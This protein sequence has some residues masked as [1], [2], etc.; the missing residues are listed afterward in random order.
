[1][2]GVNNYLKN[3]TKSI[4]Y[5]ASDIAKQDLMSE[6]M[7]F[8]ESNKEFIAATYAALKNP[9]I[10]IKKSINAIQ[11]SK[12]YQALDYGARNVVEDL[13]TGNF[14]NKERIERDSG[15]LSGMDASDYNDLSEFG[16]D[17]DWEDI[18]NDD[19]DSGDSK[20]SKVTKEITSGDIEI[21][22]AIEGTSAAST[23][24]TVNA[25][26]QTSDMQMKNARINT[27][28]LYMQNERLFGGLHKDISV[29]G[30][31]VDNIQK[32][33]SASLQNIDKNLSDFFT[34]ESK[35]SAER[36]AILK[37]MVEMQ[38]NQYKSVLDKEKE[39]A[40]KNNKKKT[41]WSDIN[42][43]GMPVFDDYIEN[44]KNNISKEMG[45]I[46]PS[47]GDGEDTNMFAVFATSPISAILSP[48]I[49]GLIPATFKLASQELDKSLSSV[50]GQFMG[51][52]A[53]RRDSG[54]IW[55]YVSKFLGVNTGV[56]R[57]IATDRYEKGPI[58]FDGITRK[59]ITD[60]IPTYL[61]RI[62]AF[63]TRE[64]EQTFDY[65][66]GRWITMNE[67]KKKHENI[68]KNAVRTSTREI[69]DAM[70]PALD[71]MKPSNKVDIESFEKAVEEFQ[72]FL[73]DH[74][75]IFNPNASRERN[76]I[77]YAR[78]PNLYK[79]YREITLAYNNFDKTI[80]HTG[81]GVKT[82]NTNYSARLGISKNV[83]DAKDSEE[84]AY[85][86]LES[87][88]GPMQQYFAAMN[89]DRHGKWDKETGKFDS[90]NILLESKDK[91]GN[92]IFSYL[93]NINAELKWQRSSGF[94]DVLSE[95]MNINNT[96]NIPT[97]PEETIQNEDANNN[98]SVNGNDSSIQYDINFR[99][100]TRQN[101]IASYN[102][103]F[104]DLD[105]N[106]DTQ[107]AAEARAERL[108][109]K[110]DKALEDIRTGKA[111]DI[112]LLS[113][114]DEEDLTSEEKDRVKEIENAIIGLTA[115]A[116]SKKY[117]EAIDALN[118]P[119][120]ASFLEENFF[121]SKIRSIEDVR[122]EVE[123]AEKESEKDKPENETE[124]KEKSIFSGIINKIKE[125]GSF[126]GGIAGASAEVFTNLMYTADRA[127]YEMMYKTELK[128]DE[129]AKEYNGF[130]DLISGK[131]NKTFDKVVKDIK[132]SVIE[133]FKKRLGI[134]DDWTDQFKKSLGDIGSSIWKNFI[135]AN[136]DVY[137]PVWGM[138]KT[139]IGVK[140][141]ETIAQ[142]QRRA[143]RQEA[144][145]DLD[146]AD[147]IKSISDLRYVNMLSA[148]GLNAMDY[149]TD[150][151]S[152]MADLRKAIQQRILKNSDALF[153]LSKD[154][155]DDEER[156]RILAFATSAQLLEI[157][158]EHGIKEEEIAQFKDDLGNWDDEGLRNYIESHIFKKMNQNA[159]RRALNTINIEDEN[160]KKRYTNQEIEDIVANNIPTDINWRQETRDLIAR[161]A[162]GK[163]R[164]QS[165]ESVLANILNRRENREKFSIAKSR[166]FG[167]GITDENEA[168]AYLS[169]IGEDTNEAI[170]K[171][172]D[173]NGLLSV[174]KV[175]ERA[176]ADIKESEYTLI[177]R[178]EGFRYNAEDVESNISQIVEAAKNYNANVLQGKTNEE[179]SKILADN[180][181]LYN[182]NRYNSARVSAL[183]FTGSIDEKRAKLKELTGR[184]DEVLNRLTTDEQLD[185]EY[186]DYIDANNLNDSQLAK[187]LGFESGKDKQIE[188]IGKLAHDKGRDDLITGDHLKTLN[189]QELINTFL[190]L[191]EA[192]LGNEITKALIGENT[193]IDAVVNQIGENIASSLHNNKNLTSEDAWSAE[194]FRFTNRGM[195]TNYKYADLM[196]QDS[197]K[198]GILR[199]IGEEANNQVSKQIDLSQSDNPI[200]TFNK[201][202]NL[203]QDGSKIEEARLSGL[204]GTIKEKRK[205]TIEKIKADAER[206]KKNVKGNQEK[207]D[208]INAE[209]DADI[210]KIES[211]SEYD[212]AEYFVRH[213]FKNNAL[214]TIDGKPFMGDTMLS[215][216]ELLFNSKGVSRVNKTD[217][218]TLKEPT[219]ILNSEDSYDLLSGL[220]V[221]KS[222]LGEK[223]TIEQDLINEN[224][225]KEK[226]IRDLPN[227]AEGSSTL[228]ITN[229]NLNGDKILAEAKSKLPEM[230]AGGLVGGVLS[231]VFDL[232]GGPLVGAAVGAGANLIKNSDTLK[233]ALFGKKIGENGERDDS[234]FISKTIVDNVR[235][236]APDM[237]K[238]GLAGIIPGLIT[239]I[240]PIGGLLA[241][242]AIGIIKNNE[243]FTNKYFGENGKLSIKSKDKEIIE[244]LIPGA[245]KG[246]GAGAIAGL[247]FGGPFGLLGNAA[248]GSVVGMMGATSEFKE[249]MLGTD[250]NG[251]REGGLMGILKEAFDPLID[252]FD[253]VKSKLIGAIDE[254]IVNPLERFISPAIHALPK[255]LSFIP[256]LVV[257][258]IDKRTENIRRDLAGKIKD[259]I[260]P[261]TEFVAKML[262]PITNLVTAPLKIPGKIV[263]GVG[264]RLR[265]FDIKHG[266]TVNMS[267]SEAVEWMDEHNWGRDV[268]PLMR[269][270]ADVKDKNDATRTASLLTAMNSTEESAKRNFNDKNHNLNRVLETYKTSD[271]RRLSKE[272]INYVLAHAKDGDYNKIASVLTDQS[273]N[274]TNHAMSQ[275][276]FE[277]LMNNKGLKSALGD[278]AEA[279]KRKEIIRT[280]SDTEIADEVTLKLKELGINPSDFDITNKKDRNKLAKYLNEQAMHLEA[281]PEEAKIEQDNHDNLSSIN[282]TLSDLYS[283]LIDRL[284]GVDKS[285]EEYRKEVDASIKSGEDKA[286]S[287]YARAFKHIQAP[288]KRAGVNTD[289]LNDKA[290]DLLTKNYTSII[291]D[292][293]NG[294]LAFTKSMS[295][296]FINMA[297]DSGISELS[298]ISFLDP[299][300][301]A[302]V[303]EDGMQAMADTSINTTQI[304]NIKKWLGSKSEIR[305]AIIKGQYPINAETVA[306]LANELVSNA[307]GLEEKCRLIN[308]AKAWDQFKSLKEINDLSLNDLHVIRT[309][310]NVNYG[311][312]SGANA[313][314][315]IHRGVSGVRNAIFHPFKTI[316]RGVTAISDAYELTAARARVATNKNQKAPE[317]VQQ[318]EVPQEQSMPI[319]RPIPSH[320][321]GTFLLSG[322][323]GIAKSILGLFKKDKS[324][325]KE[326][327]KSGIMSKVL[328]ALSFNNEKS[329]EN[330][331]PP[332]YGSGQFDETDDP[333]DGKD[334]VQIGADF[335][336]VKR[337]SDGSVEL[338]TGDSNT[339]QI[340]NKLSLKEKIAE[341]VQNAQ[342]KATEI[343]KNAF[344]TS[345]TSEGKSGKLKWW[346]I[347][348]TGAYLWKSGVLGKLYNGIVKP[349]WDNTLK[350]WIVEKALPWIK[351][352]FIPGIGQFFVNL[353][354]A[355]K[356]IAVNLYTD[357][358]KPAWTEH[359]R[360]WLV[361]D[362]GPWILDTALPKLGELIGNG[363]K[364]LVEALPTILK[365]GVSLAGGIVDAFTGNKYN[366]GDSTTINPG[367]LTEDGN[368]TNEK[369]EALTKEDVQNGNYEKI[370]NS[371]GAEGV[372]GKDGKITFKDQSMR[373]ASYLSTTANAAWHSFINPNVGLKSAEWLIKGG[374]LIDKAVGGHGIVGMA[375]GK[376]A[377]LTGNA[378][379]QPMKA[380][381][382]AGEKAGTSGATKRVISRLFKKG[383][384]EAA[385]QTVK[386]SAKE[387]AEETVENAAKSAVKEA[388]ETTAKKSNLI[389]RL[390][391]KVSSIV[392]KL[393]SNTKVGKYLAKAAEEFGESSVGQFTKKIKESIM[394][395]IEET[396]EKAAKKIGLE[397]AKELLDT[398]LV[399]LKWVTIIADFTWGFDRAESILGVTECTIG[400][401]FICGVVNVLINLVPFLSIIVS[402][403]LI[404][405]T[406]FKLLGGKD[407]EERQKEADAEYEK[408]KKENGSTKTKEEYLASKYSVTGKVGDWV[409]D[410]ASKAWNWTKDNAGNVVK[411]TAKFGAKMV[412]NPIWA[413]TDATKKAMGFLSDNK[414]GIKDAANKFATI[415]N[416]FKTFT[417]K[418]DIDS[419]LKFKYK[420]ND[421]DEKSESPLK[422]IINAMLSGYTTICKISFFPVVAISKGIHLIID[423]FKKVFDDIKNTVSKI[424]EKIKEGFEWIQNTF[425]GISDWFNN[426][427]NTDDN[428]SSNN[429]SNST[430]GAWN[431]IKFGA[432]N[433]W[434]AV[435]SGVSNAWKWITGGGT[436]KEKPKSKF[437]RGYSKQIDPAI[438]N[439]RYNDSNDTQYQT[440]G[441]SGCGPAA[442][443]NAIKAIH[444]KGNSDVVNAAT[445]ALKNGYKEKDGGTMPGFFNDY[446]N[447]NG[448]DSQT[449]TNKTEIINNINSGIPTVLMGT[450]PNGVSSSTP[451]GSNPHYVTATG[452]DDKGRVIIQ[453]PES[454]YDDQLYSPDELMDKTQFGI[455]AFGRSKFGKGTEESIWYYL[456]NTLKMTDAGAAGLMGNLYAESSLKPNNLEG[457][458]EKKYGMT[459]KSYTEAVDKGTYSKDRF[460]NDS[461]GYGLAQWTYKTRKKKLYEYIKGKGLSIASIEG[462]L[463]YL[464][465]ELSEGYKN[466]LN[467]LKKTNSLREAS[468]AVM[469]KFERPKD[470]SEKKRQQ[471]A[472]YGTKYYNKFSGKTINASDLVLSDTSSNTTTSSNTSIESTNNIWKLG[473]LLSNFLT[474]LTSDGSSSDYSSYSL[475]SNDSS[476]NITTSDQAKALVQV[477]QSQVGTKESGTNKIKYVDWITGKSGTSL[478]W[479]A[480]FVAWCANQANIPTSIIPKSS[481]C[482]SMF[483]YI[484]SHGGKTISINDAQPGDLMFVVGGTGYKHVGIVESNNGGGKV[485]TIEGNYSDKV[486]R[487]NRPTKNNDKLVFIRPAYAKA[488]STPNAVSSGTGSF[489]KYKLNDAQIK[490]VANII[491]HEQPDM[492][493]YL[494]EA[495]LMANLTDIKGDKNATPENLVKKAT[496]GWF[497]NGSSRFKNPG[498]P[499][500]SAI[501]AAKTVLVE[502][503]RTLPRYIDEHD[504]FSDI[505][506]ATNNGKAINKK[507]RSSYKQHTTKIKNKYGSNWTFY[508]FPSSG[509]DPFGYTSSANKTKWGDFHYDANTLTSGYGTNSGEKPLAKYGRFKKSIT[510]GK[511]STTGFKPI[512][513]DDEI[514][515]VNQ[516][517]ANEAGKG[518]TVV[519]AASANNNISIINL[520]NTVIKV[521]YEIADN[522][523]KLNTII[524]ILN[525][526]F[527]VNITPQ[528]VSDN[529]GKYETLKSKLQKSLSNTVMPS[530]SSNDYANTV[531]NTSMSA[532][533]EIMN[534][535][536]S[537]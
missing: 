148:Y 88:I 510:S 157:A 358:L 520:I 71:A 367:E 264:D 260:L 204:T 397:S 90:N 426:I 383:T 464:N 178:N 244:K 139:E 66:T 188:Q 411:E 220:G 415:T 74:N 110:L 102:S 373:G 222:I 68:H 11:Q 396:A 445:Y 64:P 8:A 509:S 225:I 161:N 331:T 326:S 414:D 460:V 137:G 386:T 50:F 442:A 174:S 359:L 16:I 154:H 430:G 334:I 289:D 270:A 407:F 254:N 526:N 374:N 23:N 337:G 372:V 354:G 245:L 3:V 123:K 223:S 152:A 451:Y 108:Q 217:A 341:K 94:E 463:G 344:D 301:Q 18:L 226:I 128:D 409:K 89:V 406:I 61:R 440:I 312:R 31:T 282:D 461:A 246:A 305:L 401:K 370:Y 527:N 499:K 95:L 315:D 435:K 298:R 114:E 77:D 35:L 19:F 449:I 209:R 418:G 360:P 181:Q 349:L 173:E 175:I 12:I 203:L 343:L 73:Y 267:L 138:I 417:L 517:Q 322:I 142:K 124:E 79:H 482:S 262:S 388:A 514:K 134:D 455:S 76:D 43:G 22:D 136:K 528:D 56:N 500:A 2:K 237:F 104:A 133:P 176:L 503:K 21:V 462:Q 259:F 7:D 41:R 398:A 297:A 476:I 192:D 532:V 506:S 471:R 515:Y 525:K 150:F 119:H 236:A 489:P 135:E 24:A 40:E 470:T 389:A 109:K 323:G 224:N 365:G 53:N 376:S 348:L 340:I 441:D 416:A 457:I 485:S 366:A 106:K 14:Y 210:A 412:V 495:S 221:N 508:E 250:I 420:S 493:G 100:R 522:T 194:R 295:A 200:D 357:V 450:D 243:A 146:I 345:D 390:M 269:L 501:Q 487:V 257:D 52:L 197:T 39:I 211:A 9:A 107:R 28:S 391:T 402:P 466:V 292:K 408:W 279:H 115:E 284:L 472:N 443:V 27:G 241:G 62:E 336:K 280:M 121:N 404:C 428:N 395:S 479:C 313:F 339:K 432:S 273:L 272:Q 93:R 266:D 362:V 492:K 265:R 496:G 302:L 263:G 419:L 497:A 45:S 371:E 319:G 180:T 453:D 97:P 380:A 151:D 196:G 521:L 494:A 498:N 330:Y 229:K 86:E 207:I 251:Q 17:D 324:E 144:Y 300:L 230:A 387:V 346:Q 519:S 234:G 530:S 288:L 190:E 159:L 216:G 34:S 177:S 158:A 385:E 55:S 198:E 228:N 311:T 274:G 240:G 69:M 255:L 355:I 155:A 333:N 475:L 191:I 213:G 271:G 427:F 122:K 4:V 116:N 438:S 363:V 103:I 164:G 81:Y 268:D 537:E 382:K 368:F 393:F 512:K 120:V 117:K 478:A 15:K 167:L 467:T 320:G 459:D 261:K 480:T 183:G 306:I 535:I 446:F 10:A 437:G 125:T 294:N 185:K 421:K 447:K 468:D 444:G 381:A 379:G 44:I 377:K 235:R 205:T 248:I 399:V 403:K 172:L 163:L 168:L 187:A 423:A 193:T 111:A 63:L 219:H 78:Y 523:D 160:G 534:S 46:L 48:I 231:L 422:G 347:A 82:R 127:I 384:K 99:N 165:E 162:T 140:D 332:S 47:F 439:I 30:A 58:P 153:D 317:P 37:E 392:D 304:N 291:G 536:A 533:I 208:A 32:V 327:D 214:G 375:I 513:I 424:T 378:I 352:D 299:E 212:V 452:T 465:K 87:K 186:I 490:G 338:D 410:K 130:M 276:D 325:D 143:T 413:M 491:Q 531:N 351:D 92:T 434:S 179:L 277:D 249:I 507:T 91:A 131:I 112:S 67:I 72:N 275:A 129:D 169:S 54:D 429:T 529:T 101:R 80:N 511:G 314:R 454:K 84:R 433:A 310:A 488:S 96:F 38:R 335:G 171:Y 83:L 201:V 504:C 113:V 182:I 85:R 369:G 6:T 184:S 57:G 189:N 36:N 469:L 308:Q 484:I 364:F 329:Y 239:G 456:K 394:K 233:N 252:A 195:D 13:R 400:E 49:S 296:E 105:V 242:A 293:S 458:Y 278:V 70:K 436:G 156:R 448:I 51:R 247:L 353:G 42:S 141:G 285:P 145:E 258:W 126:V 361:D 318:E 290:K 149:G 287:N 166:A 215:K 473:S 516:E 342:I 524:S 307:Q 147:D 256:K 75:G 65:D 5:T 118:S 218:Y 483:N 356:D 474:S 283:L 303:T 486:S 309:N 253:E 206:R 505:T 281:N 1:M 316:K 132:E 29:L 98:L 59:A 481:A 238:F 202:S 286:N 199:Q 328:S 170:T 518:T 33:T 405:G 227:H 321:L 425:S 431:T 20:S 26:L 477:A 60:V 232:V 25:V 350:P 502:G